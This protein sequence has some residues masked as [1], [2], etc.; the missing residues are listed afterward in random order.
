VGAVIITAPICFLLEKEMTSEAIFLAF[1]QYLIWFFRITGHASIDFVIGTLFLAALCLLIGEGTVFLIFLILRKHL[2]KKA[3]EA[4]RYQ[5]LSIRA[6]Q[7]GNKDAYQAANILAK[8]AFGHTFFQQLSLSAAF[9]WPV[10]F[11]LG[12]MQKRFLEI[13]VPIPFT[14]FSIGFIG[15]FILIYIMIIILLKI[16]KKEILHLRRHIRRTA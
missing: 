8:D 14:N 11:A 9:L 1:D 5:E 6:L 2:G 7:E 3:E 16:T 13:E 12:W 15:V 4:E 10:F